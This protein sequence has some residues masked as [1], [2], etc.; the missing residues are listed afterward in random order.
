MDFLLLVSLSNN[1]FENVSNKK[2]ITRLASHV[3]SLSDAK[4]YSSDKGS[5]DQHSAYNDAANTF[6]SKYATLSESY[7]ASEAHDPVRSNATISFAY[8][9]V[10]LVNLKCLSII[11]RFCQAIKANRQKENAFDRHFLSSK[12][13]FK[14][15]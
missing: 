10:K 4:L 1:I 14:S 2:A 3:C 12:I 8:D 9:N 6:M 15:L 7:V 5:L 13:Q 11:E